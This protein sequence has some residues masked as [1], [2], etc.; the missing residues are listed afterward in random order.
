MSNYDDPESSDAESPEGGLDLTPRSAAA[1][2]SG[3]AKK[4]G[5]WGVFVA[6]V[7]AVGFLGYSLVGAS[8]YFYNVDEAVAQRD[9]IGDKR[10]RLQGNVI[11]GSVVEGSRL[12]FVL[13]YNSVEVDVEHTGDVPDL[14]GPSIPLVVEGRFEGEEFHSDR[15]L[16]KHDETYEEDNDERLDEAE[17][18]AEQNAGA[19]AG[20]GSSSGSYSSSDTG[21]SP[22]T[23]SP[24][25]AD[26]ADDSV[27]STD[28]GS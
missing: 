22:T 27:E 2:R 28:S 4:L 8:M 13:S 3:G 25:Q 15:V 12:R 5:M 24:A 6:I 18:D 14:F 23:T 11:E 26:T 20:T 17:K 19:D 16:V 10:I 1:P 7:A 9:E 21:T